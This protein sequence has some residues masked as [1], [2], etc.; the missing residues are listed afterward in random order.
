MAD[1]NFSNIATAIQA[2]HDEI[3]DIKTRLTRN[4]NHTTRVR[5]SQR[6]LGGSGATLL[7][8]QNPVTG[9]EIPDLPTTVAEIY[10]LPAAEASR[11]LQALQVPVPAGTLARREA[12]GEQFVNY[13]RA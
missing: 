2:I 10:Q 4:E 13:Y 3:R 8:L 5:N 7:P 11:I 12:V 1:P 9:D 6:L